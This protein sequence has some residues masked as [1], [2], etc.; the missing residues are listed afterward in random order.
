MV[1]RYQGMREYYGEF[2]RHPLPARKVAWRSLDDQTL[3]L[4]VLLE[5]IDDADYP[6]SVLDVGCGVGTL[7]GYL[8][9]TDRLGDYLGVDLLPDMIQQARIA[10]PEGRFEAMDLLEAPEDW[11]FD[12][13]ICSGALNV[14]VPKH[15]I[16][17]QQMLAAMWARAE[18]A[19]AVN[20]Q[21]T[22]ALRFN[23]IAK[24][25]QDIFHGDRGTILAWCDK[26]TT[27]SVMRQDYL[28]DDAAFYLYKDYHRSCRRLE[29]DRRGD[30]RDA[31]EQAC[32]LAFLLLERELFREALKVL[33]GADDT[34]RVLNYRG[35]CH[36][37]LKN[38]KQARAY[39]V[40]AL[41]LDPS[42]EEARLNLDWISE[43]AK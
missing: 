30:R 26:L 34:A 40:A 39:Y 43:K 10:Y 27:W 15:G 42:L 33:Q 17:C 38:Y 1:D 7:Y 22:R 37:R 3:R 32:G 8:R 12:L 11:R 6:V 41:E 19:V 21:T 31:A 29:R 9:D 16:W 24:Y 14:K 25:D 2:K 28:G 36:H 13:V 18:K 35:L 20:F 23:P 5:A 4:E